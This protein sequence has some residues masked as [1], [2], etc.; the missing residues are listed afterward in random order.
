MSVCHISEISLGKLVNR[1]AKNTEKFTP[2]MTIE[3]TRRCNFSCK[4]CYCCLHEN[5]LIQKQELTLNDWDRILDE[6][7]EMGVIS[8]TFTG[9]EPLLYKNFR[10]LW[11]VAKKKGYL[12]SL[13]TNASLIDEDLADFFAEWTPTL[14]STTLYGACEDTYKRVT[15]NDG[16][17]HK[18][19]TAL[20]L[21]KQRKIHLQVKG[22]FSR[23]NKDEFHAIKDISLQYCDLFCWGTDLV[24]CYEQGGMYPE[25]VILSPKE[26]VKLELED[27]TRWA[28]MMARAEHWQPMSKSEEKPFRC[29]IGKGLFHID[30]YGGLHPCLQFDSIKYDL[31][32]GSVNDGWYN[33]IPKM[34]DSFDWKPGPCQSC[35][36]ADICMNC[37]AKAVLEGSPPTGPSE[38]YCTLGWERAKALGLLDRLSELPEIM[39]QKTNEEL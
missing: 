23:L 25:S 30:P 14:I 21:L 26:I 33:A 31:C 28:E 38:F 2:G 22:T 12:T 19:K 36:L 29:G 7:A 37:V 39:K 16:M 15:G 11:V 8:V 6:C 32:S 13:F 17:F 34:L 1:I 4:H 9:G 20:E 10:E 5:T 3:I 24:G 35:D 27:P 18:V